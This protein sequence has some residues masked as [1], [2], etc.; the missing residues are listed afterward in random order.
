MAKA[1]NMIPLICLYFTIPKQMVFIDL[2]N[3][4]VL[5]S[6]NPEF[7]VGSVSDF[8]CYNKEKWYH[9]DKQVY[10]ALYPKDKWSYY[11]V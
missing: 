6:T 2:S 11:E 7:K 3:N 4:K 5:S 1:L 8:H 10:L 9:Y